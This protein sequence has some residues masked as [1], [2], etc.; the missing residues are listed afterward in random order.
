MYPSV[1]KESLDGNSDPDSIWKPFVEEDAS[2]RAIYSFIKR[3]FVVPM[4]EV[5]DFCDTA[6]SSAK[7]VNTN[8]PTQ[9]LTLFNGDLVNRQAHHL[10]DR[11][12]REA[13]ADQGKQI[14]LAYR[15]LLAR[16]VSAQEK[17]SMLQFLSN[18]P[19]EQMTRVMFNLNEFVYPD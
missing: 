14:E 13:G 16:E 17:S 9:A 1:P 15:L 19:L 12:R 3:A 5:L 2:R 7:R 11:L 4:F 8:V 6:R 10:A 18:A